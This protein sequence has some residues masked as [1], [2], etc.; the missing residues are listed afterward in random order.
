MHSPGE[1][2]ALVAKLPFQVSNSKEG[3][4]NV[5]RVNLLLQLK[6]GCGSLVEVAPN[7]L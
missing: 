3:P 2:K 5:G 6:Q 4:E 1:N 7:N